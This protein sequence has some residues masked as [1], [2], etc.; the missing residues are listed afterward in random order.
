MYVKDPR[1]KGHI[2]TKEVALLLELQRVEKDIHRH[3][4]EAA[5][6]QPAWTAI[7]TIGTDILDVIMREISYWISWS[8]SVQAPF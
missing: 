5:G 4:E 8:N 2:L 7:I 1:G 6:V 3:T